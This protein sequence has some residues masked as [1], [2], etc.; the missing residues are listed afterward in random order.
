[1]LEV[2]KEAEVEE[3]KE[4]SLKEEKEVEIEEEKPEEE[5]VEEEL[6]EPNGSP[7]FNFTDNVSEAAQ[8]AFPEVSIALSQIGR[9]T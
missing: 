1:M 4:P 6:E 5:P 7:D 2:E 3:K 9:P 8:T